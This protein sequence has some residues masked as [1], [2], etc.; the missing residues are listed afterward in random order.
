MKADSPSARLRIEDID[1][2]RELHPKIYL[3]PQHRSIL[4]SEVVSIYLEG[5][6]DTAMA[7]DPANKDSLIALRAE[8]VMQQQELSRECRA[9]TRSMLLHLEQRIAALTEDLEALEEPRVP[10]SKSPLLSPQ[11]PAACTT[12]SS[13]TS[14]HMQELE[15][16]NDVSSVRSTFPPQSSP[17]SSFQGTSREAAMSQR[18]AATADSD[19]IAK[20]LH[21]FDHVDLRRVEEP[22]TTMSNMP[23]AVLGDVFLFLVRAHEGG[24]HGEEDHT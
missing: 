1:F 17:L 13:S 14:T 23:A 10:P 6:L 12:P 18:S 4:E 20:P 15:R 8:L 16:Q 22:A 11:L 21:S 2:C 9:P 19:G 5:P 3:E 24:V 7:M